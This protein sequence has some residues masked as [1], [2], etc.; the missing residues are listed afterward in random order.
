[1]TSWVKELL[2]DMML[3][4][5]P[6]PNKNN[7]VKYIEIATRKLLVPITVSGGIRKLEDIDNLLKAGADKVC[8]NSGVIK[9]KNFL[10]EA[11]KEFG[12][13]TITVGIDAKINDGS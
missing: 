10:I 12:S 1:M 5:P 6:L 11:V 8:V 4:L 2:L 3:W 9:D 13:S 7:L